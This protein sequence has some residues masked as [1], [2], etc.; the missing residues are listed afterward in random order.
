MSDTANKIFTNTAGQVVL[1]SIDVVIG[2]A[3]LALITRY[4]GQSNFG[5]YTTVY[6]ILQL[7][8]IVIDLGLYL[9]LLR[10]VSGAEETRIPAITNNFFTIRVIS[11]VALL[12]LAILTMSLSPYSLEVKFGTIALSVSFLFATLIAMLTAL[13]QKHLQMVKIASLN[14]VNKF[15]FFF[16]I[17]CIV[18][19]DLGLQAI[20]IGASLA[21][22]LSFALLWY[23][24]RT[25]PTPVRLAFAYDPVYWKHVL[26]I[27]WPL[28]VTTALNLI[29]FKADTV[30]L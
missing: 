19:Q 29:Y 3:S 13:F 7:F 9:T 30:I 5:H 8:V 10:E 11:S 23:L 26:T 6:A 21:S 24:L 4:L 20:F 17:I 2:I 1:R 16:A 12:A 22:A 28:A 14:L 25:I 18:V 27:S 15:L